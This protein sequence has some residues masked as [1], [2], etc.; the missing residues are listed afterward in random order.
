MKK[1]LVF[2][3]LG[4]S[5]SI[6]AQE[7]ITSQQAKDYIGK[8]VV[9]KGK[10][11]SIKL[12]SEGKSTNYINIDKAYPNNVFTVVVSNKYLEENKLDIANS[13]GKEITVKGTITVYDKDPKKTP[14]IFN[15]LEIEIQ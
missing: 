7:V 10:I 14:Q 2:L 15:P 8:E 3:V 13:V 9:L 4:F 5:T 6:F 12:A 11:A 1:F